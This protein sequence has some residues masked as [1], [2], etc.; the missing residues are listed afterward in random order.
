MDRRGPQIAH[1]C[2]MMMDGY[3]GDCPTSLHFGVHLKFSVIMIKKNTLMS[4]LSV[5]PSIVNK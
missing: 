4:G 1:Y 5:A 2:G 3:M